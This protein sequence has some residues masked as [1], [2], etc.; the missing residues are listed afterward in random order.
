MFTFEAEGIIKSS[1]LTSGH[2][3]PPP[4]LSKTDDFYL[5]LIEDTISMDSEREAAE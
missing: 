2:L 3:L 4:Q 1:V 5:H